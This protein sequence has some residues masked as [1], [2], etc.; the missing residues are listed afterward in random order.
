MRQPKEFTLQKLVNKLASL[1]F[2]Y[3]SLGAPKEGQPK[4]KKVC[5]LQMP[6]QFPNDFP[7]FMHVASKHGLLYLLT[8][9]GHFFV[10]EISS[11]AV[12]GTGKLSNDAIFIGAKDSKTDGALV[13][14]RSGNLIR[15][16]V[17]ENN[18][19][20]YI[21]TS[22]GHIPGNAQVGTKLALQ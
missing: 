12:I 6:P 20:K 2:I 21:S 13:I 8:K 18:L 11:A 5:E 4:L 1:I 19:V 16:T 14:T 9:F 7:V 22:C 15:L 3:F 17:D 10:V